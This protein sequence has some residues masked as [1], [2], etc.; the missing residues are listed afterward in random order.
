MKRFMYC[1]TLIGSVVLMGTL[2]TAEELQFPTTEQ[3]IVNALK[4]TEDQKVTGALQTQNAD[5]GQALFDDEKKSTRSI[6]GISRVV[7]DENAEKT[8]PL[9]VGALILFDT[10]S[11]VIKDESFNLLREYGK[12]FTGD[13]KDAI[14]IVAGHTDGDGTEEYNLMLSQKRAEA[15][16]QFL[17]KEFKID[18]KR[19]IVK[20]F[21]ESEPLESND[22]PE[23]K[24]KNRRVEF[25]RIE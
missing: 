6:K 16:K 10:N 20:P 3:E 21:G 8:A 23:G 24:A 1:M 17:I 5:E 11:D 4:G 2:A 25:A 13:L 15:V 9:K 19:L 22:T 12:A 7:N 18:E 14:F